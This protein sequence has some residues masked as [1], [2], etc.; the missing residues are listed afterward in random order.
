MKLKMFT[1]K[2]VAKTSMDAGSLLLGGMVSSGI[3][4]AIPIEESKT[5]KGILAAV[6]ILGAASVSGNTNSATI[7][8]NL[9]LGMGIRQGQR[10]IQEAATPSLPEADG[11]EMNKFIHDMFETGGG[12]AIVSVETQNRMGMG[13]RFTPQRQLGTT[14]NF[15]TNTLDF[16]LT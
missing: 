1:G 2:Q 7:V 11:T 9:L 14:A 4:G 12:D 16:P 13:Y 8:R 5:R 3:E 15:Q 10:F 6:G